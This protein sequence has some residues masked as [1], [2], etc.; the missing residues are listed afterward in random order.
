MF[1]SILKLICKTL[2]FVKYFTSLCNLIKF[3]NFLYIWGE[4][5]KTKTYFLGK[6]FYKSPV[7]NVW[8]MIWLL[9]HFYYDIPLSPDYQKIRLHRVRPII[10]KKKIWEFKRMK[11]NRHQHLPFCF[12]SLGDPLYSRTKLTQ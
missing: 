4:I 9:I 11:V 1:C 12:L 8:E 6:W 3:C 7:N 10:I 5:A 2:Y